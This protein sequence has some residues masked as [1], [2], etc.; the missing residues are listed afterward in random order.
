M[1]WLSILAE[2]ILLGLALWVCAVIFKL[3]FV[4]GYRDYP[5]FVPSFGQTKKIEFKRLSDILK[6]S[7]NSLNILD[8][9]CGTADLIIRLAKKFPKHNFVGI[10]WNKGL[11]RAAKF[12]S[13]N[14]T[15]VT[16]LCQDMFDY[17]FANTDIIVCFLMEP[18]MKR[19]GEKVK[20]EGKRGL[21]IYSN[22][23]NIPNLPLDE[24]IKTRKFWLFGNLY[25]YKL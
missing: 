2:L 14:L 12:K 25:I 11:Y 7:Q 17:S 21:I 4:K 19:F 15:N 9:G 13:R 20:K 10:E 6:E 22:T 8:P 3:F 18:L 16:I 1:I 24:E 5:P 23:F